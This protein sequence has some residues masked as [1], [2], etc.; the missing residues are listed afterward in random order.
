MKNQDE[1][2]TTKQNILCAVGAL[3]IV[4]TPIWVTYLLHILGA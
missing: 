4:T 1:E 3:I 2:L